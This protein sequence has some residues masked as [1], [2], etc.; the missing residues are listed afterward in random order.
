M[1]KALFF[2]F[3]L[4]TFKSFS[5][6]E[7]LKDSSAV[8]D[9]LFN[10]QPLPFVSSNPAYGIMFGLS[11]SSNF[12][13]TSEK[14]TKIS[15]AI[16][17]SDYTTLN[18]LMFALKTNIFTP[19]NKWVFSGD[20]R[21]YVTSQ[22]TY[23]LGT[24]YSK[25]PEDDLH[26]IEQPMEFNMLRFHE[27]ASVQIARNTFM[28]LGVYYDWI[29]E[30]DDKLLDVENGVYTSHYLYNTKYDFDLESTTSV[31][32]ALSLS[33]DSRDLPNNASKG[34][35]L[36]FTY[37]FYE[38]MLGNRYDSGNVYLDLRKYVPLSTKNTNKLAF[39][40]LGNFVTHGRLPYMNL[41]SIGWD[42]R[43]TSGRGYKQGRFRGENFLYTE[44]EFR[45]DLPI[46]KEK[47]PERWGYVVF[48]NVST[49]S[50]NMDEIKLFNSLAPGY[51]VGLRLML[52]KVSKSNLT[53]DYARGLNGQG[54]V[55]INYNE[56]F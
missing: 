11:L 7:T 43:G 16:L 27:T 21:F 15:S 10:I 3:I 36:S 42:Q 39:W 45:G 1:R 49:L 24:G 53:I 56:M 29:S 22:P 28:G 33:Y 17:T 8:I 25:Y 19:G 35:Y 32:L 55:Y 30:I 37:K 4:I 14:E 46:Q 12:R 54:G 31:G 26:N 44:A 20:W 40:F 48:A 9:G 23:G 47:H 34:A 52:K 2:L 5:Q 6:I 18:Q 41:T 13:F 50:S 51:G 38:S